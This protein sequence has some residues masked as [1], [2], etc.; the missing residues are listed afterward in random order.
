MILNVPSD[1]SEEQIALTVKA[2]MG[3][4]FEA[5]VIKDSEDNKLIVFESELTGLIKTLEAMRDNILPSMRQAA[6]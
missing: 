4:R 6:I 5:V 3:V 1:A 2:I